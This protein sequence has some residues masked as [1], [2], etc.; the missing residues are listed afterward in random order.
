MDRSSLMPRG[1][2]VRRFA[3]VAPAVA[4][5]LGCLMLL[6]SPSPARADGPGVGSPWAVSVGDSYISGEAGRWA[7]NTDIDI[8]HYSTID[9][10]GSEAYYDTEGGELIPGCHRSQSAEIYIGG[11]KGENLACS[12]ARTSTFTAS[13]GDFKPG[14]DFY[15][16]G[17]HEG[18]ALMLSKFAR[19]SDV[20]LVAISIG[21]NNFNFASIILSCVED[22][23][24]GEECS[25]DPSVLKNFTEANIIQ[26]TTAIR[27]A[28]ANIAKA[29]SAAGYSNSQYTIV[30]QDYPSPIPEGKGFRYPGK[31]ERL[32]TGKC[33]FSNEDADWANTYALPTIDESV[34]K[35]AEETGLP[36]IEQLQLSSAFNGRRLCETGVGLLEE[37]G[38]PSWRSPEAV[39][40]TEWINQIHAVTYRTPF[41]IQEDLH[42]NYWGQLALRNCLTQVYNAGSP[43]SGA[44][45]ISGKGLNAEGEPNMA[46]KPARPLVVH[47]RRARPHRKKRRHAHRRRGRARARR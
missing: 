35:A 27:N 39:D 13:D 5:V 2:N 8:S 36:N 29:M 31:I 16:S 1:A 34:F 14:L 12:G 41:E 17:T 44:C 7:G 30:V 6:S 18:Q 11:M 4:A 45:T 20:K 15:E 26:Q 32:F 42:P 9:A 21:G 3:F 40:K 37:E 25:K 19:T 22:Y 38:L 23:V 28:I 46:L 43:R 10:L 24:K 33:G 47:R